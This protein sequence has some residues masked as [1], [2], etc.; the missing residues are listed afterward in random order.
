[1]KNI[2]NDII[3]QQIH[4]FLNPEYVYIPMPSGYELSAKDTQKVYKEDI[5][6]SKGNSNLYSPISGTIVGKTDS[7]LLNNKEITSLVI[8]N[9]YKESVHNYKG[10]VRYI[11]DYTKKEIKDL[12]KEFHAIDVDLFTGAPRLIINGIDKD[13]YEKT[14]SFLIDTYT[15]KLLETI[16]ALIDVLD[17]KETIFTINNNDTNNVINLSS[18]IGTYP[19]I[20]LRLL[21]D[22]YPIGFKSILLKN[23]LSKKQ[24][25]EGV[26]VLTVEDLYNIYTVLKRRKPI[27]E[28]LVTISGN[29]ID[30]NMVVRT[31]V[32]V[33]ML[34]LITHTCDIKDDNFYVIVNGLISGT[35]LEDLNSV[36]T[37]DIR[38][39]FLNTVDTQKEV[40]C[41]NCGLCNLKCPVHLNPKY[42]K[43]HS[44][45]NK[46]AC[47]H[48]GL[49][50]YICPSRI[51]FK[52]YLGGTNEE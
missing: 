40:E 20:K 44:K 6:L 16:D 33:S 7:L 48:C 22:L 23:L 39:I 10:A 52:P 11:S 14:R 50:T 9:D 24:I 13:P 29:A 43:E 28:T 42:I 26:I 3:D 51:N 19:N 47:I 46:S 32:G 38:S 27:L 21:P 34:D 49:C 15:D 4:D 45:A 30:K 2:K 17:I 37:K 41:I 25:S 18:H 8:K 36:I 35:T 1:M 12:I 31:K 5:V